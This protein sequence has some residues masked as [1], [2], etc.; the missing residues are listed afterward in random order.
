MNLSATCC[1]IDFP[2]LLVL[3]SGYLGMTGASL[4]NVVENGAGGVTSKTLFLEERKGH[5]NPTV[6]TF[7]GGLIN[8][9]GLS[10]EGIRAAKSEFESYRK[11][12]P[13]NPIIASIGGKN[14][15]ELVA[16]AEIM[17]TYPV[18]MIELNF[19]CPN[20]DDEMG[21]PFA[22]D[23]QMTGEGTKAVRKVT[24]KPI[25]V[26]LSPN[27]PGIGLIAQ[28]AEAEG[29]DAITAVNTLGPGMLIDIH[30]R[31]PVLA[32]KVGGVSGMALKPIALRCVYEI[33]EHVKIPIIGTG[34]IVNGTDAIEMLMA[35]ATLLGIGSAIAYH[36]LK[37]F[38]M[39]LEKIRKFM[40][41][42]GFED[43]SDLI[44]LA[45]QR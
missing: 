12:C 1:G 43:V 29:A 18:D 28:R 9:V 5:P 7:P 38:N 44:G 15:Q 42:E 16:C 23:P 13:D 31:R 40:E 26:K 3:A 11:K 14:I 17:D 22:C 6:L 36:D 41:E 39:I 8:A 25:S 33:Y 20:V 27:F 2:N 10:G 30:M 4:A 19:S 21:R 35:G 37:A 45:H 32:N 34:G 24:K